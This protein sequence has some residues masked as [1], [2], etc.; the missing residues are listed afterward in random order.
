M[1]QY[2]IIAIQIFYTLCASCTGQVNSKKIAE[3]KHR[4]HS[5]IITDSFITHVVNLKKQE[6]RMFWKG[7]DNLPIGSIA[8]LKKHLELQNKKLLFAMN[9]G[10]YLQNQSP[11][12]LYIE[13][14]KLVQPINLDT[15]NAN[16][17]LMPN[18]IFFVNNNNTA[19]VCTSNSIKEFS[20]I[21]YATQ[22]GPMLVID[23]N[24]HSQFT[25]GSKRVNIRN[26]VGILPNGNILFAM[27][28]FELS[29][30]DFAQYFLSRGCKN[31]LYLDG[32]V[33]RTYLPEKNWQQLDGN[34]GVM[35]AEIK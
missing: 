16:F 18:G 15:G 9:G 1:K 22:S 30:Y 28:T 11:Q 4:D 24:I 21:K 7:N 23:S 12:G 31:A 26:G 33:S 35:I 27:T 10:M 2:S 19:H 17:Y 3:N 32:Y 14:N 25:K 8:Q 29:M 6:L 34:F 5:L 20:Q 13:N